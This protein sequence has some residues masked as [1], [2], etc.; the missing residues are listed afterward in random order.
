MD[1]IREILQIFINDVKRE[2]GDN[3]KKII[4]YGSYA[5]GDYKSNSDIDI[6]ILTSLDEKDIR[7]YEEDITDAAFE[8][9]MYSG[10]DISV[11]V[12]NEKQ[13]YYWVGALPFYDNVQKDGVLLYG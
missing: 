7:K 9:Q 2:F 10:K 1:E 5:R 12:K 13:F 11:I 4:L 6:M 8:I 3:L